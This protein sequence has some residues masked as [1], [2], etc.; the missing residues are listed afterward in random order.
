MTDS[1]NSLVGQ[2]RGTF[3]I[4]GND[5]GIL[6]LNIENEN[7]FSGR[8]SFVRVCN[9]N[10]PYFHSEIFFKREDDGEKICG[11]LSNFVFLHPSFSKKGNVLHAEQFL[12]EELPEK[13]LKELYSKYNFPNAGKLQGE[14]KG[15]SFTGT[16]STKKAGSGE[17]GNFLLKKTDVKAETNAEETFKNWGEFKEWVNT[18]IFKPNNGDEWIFRGQKSSK[19]KMR[20][21]FHRA[22]RN[23]LYC[24]VVKDVPRLAHYINAVSPYIYDIKGPNDLGAL[25]SLG[26]HHGFPTPFLDWTESPYVAAFFAFEDVKQ[27]DKEKDGQV[28]IFALN[29]TE[30]EENNPRIFSLYNPKPTFTVREPA[31]RAGNERALAQQSIVTYSNVDDIEDFIEKSKEK[32]KKEYLIRIDLPVSEKKVAMQELR[33]MGIHAASLFLDLDG[34]CKSLKEKYFSE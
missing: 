22:G 11:N 17:Q 2:W 4:N 19:K 9:N 20:T 12:E 1:K 18:T 23:D 15:D 27:E 16:W 34:I 3:S 21:S 6:V 10:K 31:I 8:I 28:R 29:R 24:Y 33:L 5:K 14:L 13:P 7:P 30:W 26:Q 25:L 32:Y